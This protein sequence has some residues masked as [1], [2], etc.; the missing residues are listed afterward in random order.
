MTGMLVPVI[1]HDSN[2][3]EVLKHFGAPF[4]REALISVHATESGKIL[5]HGGLLHTY[6]FISITT[7]NIPMGC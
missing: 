5:V 3:V 2:L 6:F 4:R 7:N 1:D